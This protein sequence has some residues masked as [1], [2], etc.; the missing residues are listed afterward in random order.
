MLRSTIFLLKP[1]DCLLII[2]HKAFRIVETVVYGFVVVAALQ[3]ETFAKF[4]S[5]QQPKSKQGFQLFL[6]QS[7]LILPNPP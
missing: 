5:F 6:L 1:K 7:L 3:A 2:L 4:L